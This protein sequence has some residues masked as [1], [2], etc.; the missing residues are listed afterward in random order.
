MKPKSKPRKPQHEA[1]EVT[2]LR[3]RLRAEIQAGAT[4][5]DRVSKISGLSWVTVAAFQQGETQPRKRVIAGIAAALGLTEP[6]HE[7]LIHVD[8]ASHRHFGQTPVPQPTPRTFATD[9]ERISYALGVL[10]MAGRSNRIVLETSNEVS[11]AI[12]AASAALLAPLSGPAPVAPGRTDAEYIAMHDAASQQAAAAVPAT[13]GG[14][15][16]RATGR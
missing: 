5:I 3:D 1:R 4:T 14:K 2:E 6:Q 11:R 16:R 15:R 12:S 13:Q 9:A 7:N 8:A 10:D